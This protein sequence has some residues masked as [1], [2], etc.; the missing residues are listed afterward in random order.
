MSIVAISNT[1]PSR[2]LPK[3][4]SVFSRFLAILVEYDRQQ[5][6]AEKLRQ[7]SDWMLDDIGL[8]RDQVGYPRKFLPFG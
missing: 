6:E 8:T 2:P 1:G 3:P 5:R 4:R 7:M